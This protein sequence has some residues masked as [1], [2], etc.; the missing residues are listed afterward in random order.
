[1]ESNFT[2]FSERNPCVGCPA[3]CCQ[4]QLIPFKTPMTFMDID[5]LHYMLLF[6]KTEV[7]VALNGE[8]S[9]IRWEACREFDTST[10]T[11][12]LHNTTAKPQTCAMYNPYNCWYKRSFVLNGSH[13]IYRMNLARFEVWVNEI[14]FAEDGQIVKA[15]DFERSLAILK[16]MPIEPRLEAMT[17]DVLASDARL[18]A[19]DQ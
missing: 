3:P 12:K 17:A 5:F 2:E 1:M 15:P 18:V 13:Q 11:C 7:V 4:M 19:A 6:P 16:D 9:I 10:N 8:W 14:Q